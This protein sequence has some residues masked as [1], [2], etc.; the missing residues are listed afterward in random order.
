M[1]EEHK[2]LEA[3]VEDAQ[4]TFGD[5]KILNCT[6][7]VRL[8][9]LSPRNGRAEASSHA[10]E[11][12]TRN[13]VFVD[14]GASG[15]KG[16]LK[17]MSIGRTAIVDH[18]TAHREHPG[19][20]VVLRS[21][22]GDQIEWQCDVPFRVVDITMAPDGH[23]LEFHSHGKP[24]KYPFKTPLE[25]LRKGDKCS[26]I[27]SGPIDVGDHGHWKQ[28]YKAHFELEIDGVWRKLDPDFYCD[29]R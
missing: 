24:P 21:R 25:A 6:K 7:V 19:S 14:C 10:D 12:A 2:D 27:R 16:D 11:K 15:S 8:F 13:D 5:P 4:R 28:L 1:S 26:P 20:I 17:A 29:A 3:P 23:H 9:V 22:D 18:E